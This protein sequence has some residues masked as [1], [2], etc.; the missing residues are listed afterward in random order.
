MIPARQTA[1]LVVDDEAHNIE[2][3]EVVL[4]KEGYRLFFAADAL[5]ALAVLR[6][7]RIDVLVLDLM[8]PGMDG[9]ELLE[10]LKASEADVRMRVV[11]VSALGDAVTRAKALGADDFLE[12][13]YD[14]MALKA[15]IK[16]LLRTSTMSDAEAGAFVRKQFDTM[17]LFLDE[18]ILR[19]VAIE[20]LGMTERTGSLQ[21][22]LEFLERFCRQEAERYRLCGDPERDRF[23]DRINRILIRRRLRGTHVEPERLFAVSG[24]FFLPEP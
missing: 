9:F 24:E 20:F 5:E 1:I 3:A 15:V 8:M 10:T 18:T 11:V 12:K 17:A 23:Q 4:K 14:I 16:E 2:L 13:P 19:S 6:Q 21:A 7:Q 22:E